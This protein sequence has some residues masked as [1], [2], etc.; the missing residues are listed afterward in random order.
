MVDAQDAIIMDKFIIMDEH[1][2]K[3]RKAKGEFD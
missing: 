2:G 1:R 3:I